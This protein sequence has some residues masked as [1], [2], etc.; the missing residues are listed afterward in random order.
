MK[1][2]HISELG[3]MAKLRR[4]ELG[5]TQADVAEAAG[6][7]IRFVSDLERGKPTIEMERALK[8]VS[9]L[10][11]DVLAAIRGDNPWL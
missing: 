1:I 5:Y 11:I 4:K 6:V 9:V 2:T 7:G 10:G 8:V 3:N